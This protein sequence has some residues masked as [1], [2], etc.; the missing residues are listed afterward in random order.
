MHVEASLDSARLSWPGEPYGKVS[1]M[2]VYGY[3]GVVSG[4]PVHLN[5][6]QNR[7][8]QNIIFKICIIQ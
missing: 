5:T 3:G 4:G 8:E 1:T 7:T 2:F 6:K